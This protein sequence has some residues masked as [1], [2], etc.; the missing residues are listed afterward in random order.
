LKHQDRLDSTEKKSLLTA[1]A[2]L[3]GSS[4]VV[5]S[6][7]MCSRVA[8]LLRDVVIARFIGADAMA[9]A[10]FVAFKIPNFFR[11]LFSE[12]AFS[13]AFVPVLAEYRETGS[14]AAVK[15]LI[16][17]VAG[18]LG[19]ILIALTVLFVVAAPLITGI[20]AFGFWLNDPEK[21]S[22]ASSMLR[23]TFPYLMLISLTGFAG[24]ILNS[25]NRF[26]V[27]AITPIFLNITLIIAAIFISPWFDQP[28]YALAWGVLTAGIIQLLFQLPFLAK[29]RMI[30]RPV[31]KLGDEGV[32]KILKLMAPAIFGVSV[33]QINLLLDTMIASLLPTGSISWLYYSDRLAELPLGVFGIA[34]ATVILPNLSRQHIAVKLEKFS[35]I[36]D[37]AIRLVLLVAIP[38]ALALVILAEPILVSLFYY[39]EVMTPR[40]IT[41]AV[42]SLRAYSVGVVAFMLIKVLAPGYFSRQ[43]MRTPVRIGV[44]ALTVNM[45]L[46]IILATPLHFYFGLGHVGLAAATSLAAILNCILLFRGLRENGAYKPEPGWRKFFLMLFNANIAM[47]ATLYIFVTYQ[48]SWS[49]LVWWERAG[50]LSMICSAGIVVYAAI[51]FLGGFRLTHLK[52]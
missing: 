31:V 17:S 13:Q 48:G 45:V 4:G 30:P 47:G 43:D 29:I 9:D 6:M 23:I 25:F 39:G 42:Y 40:D 49:E 24:A 10:F 51:L 21:F 16:D 46:N 20:F 35:S 36:L 28:V 37:W 7:T 19:S 32:V 22:A 44:I 8:G 34:I 11:R 27:P 38:A 18:V 26:A 50:S 15:A 3:L 12:G 41:M 52:K 33:S 14:Q 5:A 2:G 1:P